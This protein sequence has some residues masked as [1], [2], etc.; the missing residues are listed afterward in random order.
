[1]SAGARWCDVYRNRRE[2]LRTY[3]ALRYKR[4]RRVA[5]LFL[6]QRSGGIDGCSKCG[7]PG[8]LVIDHRDPARKRCHP[9]QMVTLSLRA[10]WA[11]LRE[12][13]L[14]CHPCD[15]DKTFGVD[16]EAIQAKRRERRQRRQQARAA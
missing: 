7:G 6:I 9:S 2:Y 15:H 5:I 14:L 16:Q 11:E 1:M 10:L 8:P 12:C 3:A 13:W 4:R